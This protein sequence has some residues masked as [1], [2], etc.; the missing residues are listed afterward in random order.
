MLFVRTWLIPRVAFWVLWTAWLC[1]LQWFLLARLDAQWALAC[2]LGPPLLIAWIGSRVAKSPL[3]SPNTLFWKG[4]ALSCLLTVFAKLFLTK[5]LGWE[6]YFL[7]GAA[8]LCGYLALR[9]RGTARI[10]VSQ[11]DLF[12]RAQFIA[13]RSGVSLRSVVVFK[14]P[15]DQP[16]AFA[17]RNSG[18]ILLSDRLLRLLS[19]RETEAVIAHEAS[20]LRPLQR[21]VVYAVPSLA[22]VVLLGKSAWPEA[23]Y[24]I[25]FLPILGLLLWRALRRRQEYA[26]DASAVRATGDPEALISALTRISAATAMPLHW[27]PAAGLFLPHP[28]MTARFRSIALAG[29]IASSRVDEIVSSIDAIPP[30]PGFASPFDQTD[31]AGGVL[32]AH[33]A[34]LNKRLRLLSKSFPI[35][36]GV[37]FAAIE[38]FAA[39]DTLGLIL[40]VLAW[41]AGSMV[42]FWIAYEVLVGSERRRVR[43]QLPDVAGPGGYFAGLS[44]AVEPRSYDGLYHYDLG[45]M[46]IQGGSLLFTGTRCKFSLASSEAR[47]IF[48]ASGPP[49]WTPRKIVCIEY[50]AQDGKTGVV[51]LQSLERRFWPATA[52]AAQELFTA[53]AQWSKNGEPG[54]EAAAPPPQFRGAAMPRVRPAA[55]WNSIKIPCL[56]TLSASVLIARAIPAAFTAALV[57]AALLLFLLAPHVDWS[58]ARSSQASTYAEIE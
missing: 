38:R 53:I 46:R 49:H 21:T 22:A 39:P 3:E 34:I 47:R 43:A 24:L 48:L 4:A 31:P 7:P 16:S 15:R 19:R 23:G 1:T 17:Q 12:E 27:S 42:V 14:S 10:A 29:G 5:D 52:A 55:L 11:G 13:R 51:S 56:V 58:P 28:P 40:Q 20:H 33:R 9:R 36:A 26:A 6:A 30:L 44:T 57:T 18:A 32:L 50:Q 2:V 35:L 37:V 54:A 25:P 8:L 41:T 45:L